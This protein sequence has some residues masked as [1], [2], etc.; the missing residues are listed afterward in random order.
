MWGQHDEA[1]MEVCVCVWGVSEDVW[2]V[3]RGE[4]DR[5]RLQRK[6]ER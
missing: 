2:L 6:V 3:D 1:V 5:G 4:R